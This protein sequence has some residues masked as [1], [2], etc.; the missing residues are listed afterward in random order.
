MRLIETSVQATFASPRRA[1]PGQH[2]GTGRRRWPKYCSGL[3][4]HGGCPLAKGASQPAASAPNAK[5]WSQP[6]PRATSTPDPEGQCWQHHRPSERLTA[7][8]RGGCSVALSEESAS[9]LAGQT[10]AGQYAVQRGGSSSSARWGSD[11]EA[12][13]ELS[14]DS[15]SPDGAVVGEPRR[16]RAAGGSREEIPKTSVALPDLVLGHCLSA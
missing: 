16:V 7:V 8:S 15:V 1:Y 11:E 14:D 9:S 12:G 10:S 2:R 5:Q 13:A 6:T 3:G 4:E